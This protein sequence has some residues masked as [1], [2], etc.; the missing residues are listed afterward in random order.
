MKELCLNAPNVET[1]DSRFLCGCVNF[2]KI[3]TFRLRHRHENN[4]HCS[5]QFFD[6]FHAEKIFTFFIYFE[7]EIIISEYPEC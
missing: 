4:Q 7:N 5:F 3:I 2:I 6:H 1:H